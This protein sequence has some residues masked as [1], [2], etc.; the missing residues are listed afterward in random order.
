MKWLKDVIRNILIN[1]RGH[2]VRWVYS[3]IFKVDEAQMTNIKKFY[4]NSKGKVKITSGKLNFIFSDLN[5]ETR[6]K[7][8]LN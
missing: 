6:L 7:M 5:Y 3:I 8:V 1:N 4:Y 2:V